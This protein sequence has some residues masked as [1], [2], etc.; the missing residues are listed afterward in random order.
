MAVR[1]GMWQFPVCSYKYGYKQCCVLGIANYLDCVFGNLL[2]YFV[3]RN[4]IG[5]AKRLSEAR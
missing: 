4:V 1:T 5:E 2:S 3:E